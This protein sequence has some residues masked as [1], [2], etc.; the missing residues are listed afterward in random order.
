MQ[1]FPS[2][3]QLNSEFSVPIGTIC[4]ELFDEIKKTKNKIISIIIQYKE[5]VVRVGHTVERGFV[6]DYYDPTSQVCIS[7]IVGGIIAVHNQLFSSLYEKIHSNNAD[8]HL[9]SYN[10]HYNGKT[11]CVTVC[12]NKIGN[13]AFSKCSLYDSFVV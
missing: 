6:P 8:R 11:R 4:G 2:Y 10:I 7:P 9:R 1:K 12:R 13:T 5:G 3:G